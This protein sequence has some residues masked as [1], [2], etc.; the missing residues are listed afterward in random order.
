M[1][2]ERELRKQQGKPVGR[3]RVGYLSRTAE[4][5]GVS[6]ETVSAW[7]NRR[8]QAMNP[9]ATKLI[10]VAFQV[11]EK[12]TVRILAEDLES[13]RQVLRFLRDEAQK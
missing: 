7:K 3:G 6:R 8:Y 10:Q 2:E 4:V 11:D 5:L 1:D 12:E 13:H 9:N